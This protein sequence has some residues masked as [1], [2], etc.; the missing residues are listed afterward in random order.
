VRHR[1]FAALVGLLVLLVVPFVPVFPGPV[2]YRSVADP[3]MPGALPDEWTNSNQPLFG[4]S[5]EYIVRDGRLYLRVQALRFA[6][7]LV[8]GVQSTRWD[9]EKIVA[10]RSTHPEL[11]KYWSDKE[12]PDGGVRW[13]SEKKAQRR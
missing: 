6:A 10:F 2:T 1:V 9:E 4:D 8:T 13:L 12:K 3:A 11:E 7:V 5:S